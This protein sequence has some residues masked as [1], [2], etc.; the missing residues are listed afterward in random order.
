MTEVRRIR[1][2]EGETVAALWDEQARTEPDGAPLPARGR[3]NITRMLDMAAW[4]E[5]Q[6]CLVAVDDERIVGFVCASIDAGSGLLPGLVGEVDALYVM[7][8]ARDQGV[9]GRLTQSIVSRL[10]E[11]GAGTIRSLV[12]IENPNAQ[13]FWQAQGF[14]RDMVCMS[15][16]PAG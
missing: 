9:S 8:T 5:R 14:E 4:H 16:Y 6:V 2:G 7:P 11:R 3:R 13:A 10:R 1:E 15:L 12:C